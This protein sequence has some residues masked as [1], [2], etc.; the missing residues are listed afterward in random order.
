M[1][2]PRRKECSL[3]KTG[4]TAAAGALALVLCSCAT[5]Y[6]PLKHGRG[7]FSTQVSSDQFTVGFQ[8]NADTSLERVYDLTLLRSAEV[9]LTNGFHFFSVLDVTNTSSSK[10][11][12][13]VYQTA[14]MVPVIGLQDFGRYDYFPSPARVQ[15]QE[16][17]VY[18]EPGT[19]LYIQC[20]AR[21]P[22]QPFAYDA[23]VL[24]D[25]LKRKYKVR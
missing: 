22:E 13:A 25:S 7:Y 4:V 17:R 21:R 9:T 19:V 3:F 16:P 18:Y 6:H 2:R 5:A 24:E 14:S 11:F 12:K 15:V 20:F 8:G 23:A 1:N 10:R